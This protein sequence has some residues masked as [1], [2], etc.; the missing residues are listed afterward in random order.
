MPQIASGKAIGNLPAAVPIPLNIYTAFF[1]HHKS[2]IYIEDYMSTFI[3]RMIGAA[4]LDPSLFE[5]LI[6]DPKTQGQSVWVVAIFAM[7]TGFGLFSRA[8]AT[9]VNSCLVTTFFAWYFWAFTLYFAGTYLFREAEKKADRKTVMRLMAFASAPG[10]LRV[11]GVIPQTSVILFI[12]TSVWIIA[13]S[14]MGIKMAFE[15]PNTGKVILLCTGT[16][17]LAFFVQILLLVMI[18]SALGVS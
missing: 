18:F 16:W 2:Y 15:I 3:S 1:V 17:L 10:I 11:L 12:V 5:E 8:G 6:N 9:A 7:T 14:V 4:K 13:A